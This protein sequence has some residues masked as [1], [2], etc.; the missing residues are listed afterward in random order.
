MRR[1]ALVVFAIVLAL[2]AAARAQDVPAPPR[3]GVSIGVATN[4]ALEGSG[5]W[6]AP[7]IRIGLP[8][9]ARASVDLESSAVFGG[10][11]PSPHGSITSFLALNARWLIDQRKPDGTARYWITGLRYSPIKWPPEKGDAAYDDD[12]A[13]TIGYGWDQVLRSRTRVGTEM[14]FSG[15]RGFLFFFTLN[16]GVSVYR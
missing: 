16:V 11:L 3:E 7:G 1:P 15:G 4:V 6:F 12:L 13:F 8:L 14:G 10:R 5:P 9:A 2:T